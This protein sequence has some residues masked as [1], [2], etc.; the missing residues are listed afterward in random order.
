MRTGKAWS[1]H[2][3]CFC[4]SRLGGPCL[5][6]SDQ[7]LLSAICRSPRM[8]IRSCL[9]TPPMQTVTPLPS[10]WPRGTW[11][12]VRNPRKNEAGWQT[13]SPS[14]LKGEHSK[15]LCDQINILPLCACLLGF[16]FL[17]PSSHSP[18]RAGWGNRRPQGEVASFHPSRHLLF[19]LRF[20]LCFQYRFSMRHKSYF[21]PEAVI[22]LVSHHSLCSDFSEHS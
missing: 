13:Q 22:R 15:Q 20:A 17:D 16:T 7:P 11:W 1:T 8:T 9:K 21:I 18:Y 2:I 6:V 12:L 4:K 19:Q 5:G 10:M 3:R 14:T